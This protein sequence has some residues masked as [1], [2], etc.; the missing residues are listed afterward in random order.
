MSRLYG[1]LSSLIAASWTNSTL[2]LYLRPARPPALQRTREIKRI[3]HLYPWAPRAVPL[4]LYSTLYLYVRPARPPA[5]QRTRHIKRMKHCYPWA[6]ETGARPNSFHVTC[7]PAGGPPTNP[8]RLWLGS[9]R[10]RSSVSV[11]VERLAPLSLILLPPVRPV[12][13]YHHRRNTFP[14]RSRVGSDPIPPS[15]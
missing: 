4:Q 1:R 14:L 10:T 12:G 9:N 7:V 2:Q 3:K 15:E 8:Q 11:Q 5:L 6:P 13:A